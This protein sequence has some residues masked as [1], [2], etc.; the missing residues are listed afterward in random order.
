M[1]ADKALVQLAGRPLVAHALAVLHQAGLSA[2]IAGASSALA[3]YAPVVEDSTPGL[4][5]LSGVCAALAS[6]ANRYAVFL[7]VDLPLLPACLV[8]FLLHHAQVTGAAVTLASVNGFAQTFP[9]VVDRR[10][11]PLLDSALKESHRGCFSAFQDAAKQLDLPLSILPVEFLVQ[12]GNVIH[13]EGMPA[14]FWF[15]NVNTRGEL[16]RAESLLNFRH[17]VI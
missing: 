12:T 6:C 5:P 13:P 17:S 10:A 15:H 7:S 9:A 2:T 14:A 16:E 1:G 4:G 11:L 8:A 3:D